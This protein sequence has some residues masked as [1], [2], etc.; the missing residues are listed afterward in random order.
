MLI[1]IKHM[2]LILYIQSFVNS[3]L[4]TQWRAANITPL[5]KKGDKLEAANYRPVL[6]TSITCKIM[7]GIVRDCIQSYLM[8]YKLISKSQHGFVKEKSCT[9]NLLEALDYVSFNLSIGISVDEA[10]LDFVK[11]FDSVAHKRLLVKLSSYGISGLL[12][13]RIEAFLKNRIQRVIQDDTKILSKVNEINVEN[14]LQKDLDCAEEWS[15]KWLLGFNS[16]KCVIMHYGTNNPRLK[17]TLNGV[18]LKDSKC[19]RDLGVYFSTN[20]KWKKQIIS[21]TS[22]ANSMM[23]MLKMTFSRID[24]KLVKIL[25]K[26][27]NRPL[28]EFAV[29]VWSPYFK[30]DI[31]LLEKVQHRMTSSIIKEN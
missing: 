4:P 17:Y 31:S 21:S 9:T 27:F 1:S 22:K 12:L 28:I 10:L 29:P 20:L 2:E 24:A 25:Y 18:E 30:G 26:V 14:S 23:G 6:L 19:E 7:E 8:K 15:K 3:E 13:K 11:A 16:S 5:F